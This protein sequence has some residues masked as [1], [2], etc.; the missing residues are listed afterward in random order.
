M[1]SS[2]GAAHGVVGPA[3]LVRP[4]HV[5]RARAVRVAAQVALALQGA[6]LVVHRGGGGE[7]HGVADL[8][9]ARRVAEALDP[10]A[11]HLQHLALPR[12]QPGRL[13]R[14]VGERADLCRPVPIASRTPRCAGRLCRPRLPGSSRAISSSSSPCRRRGRP[15]ARA[16]PAR[17]R[18]VRRRSTTVAPIPS[19]AKHMFERHARISRFCRCP[20]VDIA[21]TFVRTLV[22]ERAASRGMR[23]ATEMY[24]DERRAGRPG[25]RRSADRCRARVREP[26]GRPRRRQGA[27][28]GAGRAAVAATPGPR[29]AA[30]AAG[31]GP[32]VGR[33]APGGAAGRLV[34]PARR[35]CGR[36]RQ[37][38]LARRPQAVAGRVAPRRGRRRCW[39]GVAGRGGWPLPSWSAWGQLLPR[40]PATCRPRRRCAVRPRSPSRSTPRRRSGMSRAASSPARRGRSWPRWRSASSWPTRCHRSSCRSGPGVAGAVRLT[41]HP[42]VCPASPSPY[43]LWLHSC[44]SSMGGVTA[45]V[46]RSQLREDRCAA[47]SAGTRTV[48]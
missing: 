47:R 26:A 14:R 37:R 38:T 18:P 29:S 43:M 8:P 41:P 20:V 2:R 25:S 39:P 16:T 48:G 15:C 5:D 22:W 30:G 17:S 11:D 9:D 32:G 12:G 21:Q 36:R 19:R 42:M 40:P 24:D 34:A 23:R 10:V 33:P 35:A 1:L 7:A 46:A 4:A 45:D 13:G 44:C 6:Q 31:G 28:A 3:E 27:G